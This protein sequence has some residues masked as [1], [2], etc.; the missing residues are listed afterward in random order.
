MDVIGPSPEYGA[1]LQYYYDP[2]SHNG[3]KT[4][5]ELVK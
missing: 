3:D 4:L 1:E 2:P 5:E